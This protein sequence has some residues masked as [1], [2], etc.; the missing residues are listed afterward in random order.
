[1]CIHFHIQIENTKVSFQ[2]VRM[3]RLMCAFL[4]R[5]KKPSFCHEAAYL[6]YIIKMSRSTTIKIKQIDKDVL[7]KISLRNPTVFSDES[8]HVQRSCGHVQ[9]SCG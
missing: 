9:K 3:L 4:V 8:S 7:S 5:I 2:R 1:M 6:S